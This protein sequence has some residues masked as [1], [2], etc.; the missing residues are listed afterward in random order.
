MIYPG[1]TCLPAHAEEKKTMS[2][3]SVEQLMHTRIYRIWD[4]T[5]YLALRR[6]AR[7]PTSWSGSRC[8]VVLFFSE[9]IEWEPALRRAPPGLAHPAGRGSFLPSAARPGW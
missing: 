1:W 4:L 8:T 9:E 6:I 5:N 7:D 3:N 2:G